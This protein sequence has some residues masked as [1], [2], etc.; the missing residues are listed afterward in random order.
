MSVK[1]GLTRWL[2]VASIVAIVIPAGIAVALPPCD[3]TK[4][5]AQTDCGTTQNCAD[6]C[7]LAG[8]EFA[9]N[10]C[11]AVYRFP[12]HHSWSCE[13]GNGNIRCEL[14]GTVYPCEMWYGCYYTPDNP[15]CRYALAYPCNFP[16]TT[17]N[18]AVSVAC[19]PGT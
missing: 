14:N 7:P 16:T 18:V 15:D 12:Q 1:K 13:P 2:A 8:A 4:P 3:A 6:D 17:Q 19:Q 11:A 9:A 5:A 10:P